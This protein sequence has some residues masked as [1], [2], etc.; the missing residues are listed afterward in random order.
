MACKKGFDSSGKLV[1]PRTWFTLWMET[2]RFTSHG[3][4]RRLCYGRNSIMRWRRGESIGPHAA[5]LLRSRWPDCPVHLRGGKVPMLNETL[6]VNARTPRIYKRLFKKM[7]MTQ[8]K[9]T[10][11]PVALE[12]A[13]GIVVGTPS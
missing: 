3:L 2:C 10:S 12:R 6:P 9:T 11:G 13:R 8:E 5:M 1:E 4:A 7:G